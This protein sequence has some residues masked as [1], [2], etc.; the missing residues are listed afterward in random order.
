[1]PIETKRCLPKE[2]K[3]WT[4]MLWGSWREELST[5]FTRRLYKN[6]EDVCGGD[7]CNICWVEGLSQAPIVRLECNHYFHYRCVEKKIDKK[8]PAAR[9]TFKF[10]DCPL[11]NKVM[12]HQ[13]LR[14]LMA[15]SLKL[16]STIETQAL[17]RLK[18]EG[19]NKDKRIS[20]KGGKYFNNPALFALDRL[21]FYEC[22]KCQKPYFG[23]MRKC[24]EAGMEQSAK[25]KKEH[26]VCGSCA[27][28]PNSASCKLHGKTYI[29]YKCKFCCAVA[30]WFCWGNTHFCTDCHKKQE[31]G[32]YLNRKPISALPKCP[33]PE[34]CPLK[35]KHPANGTAEFSLGCVVC[36][37]K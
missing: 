9:I 5:V 36:L 12:C 29:T 1:M 22:F 8:W 26:L 37:R 7:Y 20:Q 19:L 32:D 28:G 3:M 6:K 35:I 27:S 25:F 13:A 31:K 18:V 11:C 21:A 15:P 33:G 17:D 34:K 10:M 23:G 30:N 24:E 14:R 2:I 4:F 16:K